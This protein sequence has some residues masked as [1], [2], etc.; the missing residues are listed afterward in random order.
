VPS[1]A[2]SQDGK[3]VYAAA[4]GS[5]AVEVFA[6]GAG[7]ALSE[8][9]CVGN[10]GTGPQSCTGVSGLLQPL[11]VAIAGSGTSESLDVAARTGLDVFS[12][13]TTGALTQ[14]GCVISSS[15]SSSASCATATG[16]IEPQGIAVGPTASNVYLAG[17]HSV[18]EF[19]RT[20]TT[21]TATTQTTTT[22]A[23]KP[24][25]GAV[26]P[27]I[28]AGL[29]YATVL[30]SKQGK[31]TLAV[32]VHVSETVKAELQLLGARSTLLVSKKA[33]LTAGSHT[34]D[35]PLTSAVTPGVRHLQITLT[36]T[37]KHTKTLSTGVV[38]QH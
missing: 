11:A 7:G 1:I 30:T 24:K 26:K 35:I 20:P 4:E 25:P 33:T 37:A 32:G 2:I 14:S 18:V 12:V 22:S 34:I 29:L 38:I 6:R 28:T 5:D 21:P 36:D 27:A 8:V 10:S 16:L 9:G 31:R 13:G 17:S 23:G 19:T 15:S 3:F